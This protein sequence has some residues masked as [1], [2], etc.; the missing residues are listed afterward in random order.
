[1]NELLKA[2]ADWVA[3][4]EQD[5]ESLQIRLNKQIRSA[6]ASLLRRVLADVLPKLGVKDGFLVSGVGNLAKA[7]LIERV[8]D[9]MGK[10]E[11]NAVLIAYSD[12][13]LEISGKNAAYYYSIGFDRE[14]VAAIAQDLT[15][16]RGL[17]G[18]DKDGQLLKDGFLYRLG[19]SDI[20]RERVKQYV[21]TSIATKQSLKA[22]QSGLSSLIKGNKEVDGALLG[23]WNGYAYDAYS[24]VREVDN[25]HF[26]DEIGLKHFMYQGGL[27]KT[28]RKFCIKKNGKVFTEEEAKK[29]WPKDP[30]LIDKAHLSTY[31]PLID[32]G[33]NNCR[34][35]LMWITEERYNEL[36]AAQ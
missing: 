14:K 36:K 12:A 25:L 15:L 3:G 19:K 35:F 32:R 17:I 2:I 24:K 5:F 11:I 30:D 20:V 1:M 21:L 33:R 27:I 28:S 9:E 26:K 7:N 34:H 18:I 8:F 23:Y 6:E 22:F 29:N 4:F 13:L 31:N 10:D 16:I